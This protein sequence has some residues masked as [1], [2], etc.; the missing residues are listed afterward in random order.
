MRF[1]DP[2]EGHVFVDGRDVRSYELRELR[3]KFGVVFQN[4]TLFADTIS[5]NIA[6]GRPADEESI[7]EAAEDACA[8]EF[9]EEYDDG[10]SHMSEIRGS[11]FSG[12]QK[13]R[14]LI[15]RAL[16]AK[17]EILILDDASSALDYGTDA[18]LRK[19]LK[20]NHADSTCIIIAQRISRLIL[21]LPSRWR[22]C[23]CQ[24]A[25][26]LVP[27]VPLATWLPFDR[28]VPCAES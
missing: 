1:Y 6:F 8:A 12:G 11:N 16:A 27:P 28:A 20:E 5:G 18:K 2:D 4:D 13:Q 24:R 26:S 22:E 25:C 10:Y 7:R 17:P 23:Q 19:A 3:K 21:R 15:A 14:L 9:I